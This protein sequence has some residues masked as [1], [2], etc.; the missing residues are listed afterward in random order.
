MFQSTFDSIAPLIKH[1]Y[2]KDPCDPLPSYV[3]TASIV[4]IFVSYGYLE[5][6][7]YSEVSS[8][9]GNPS[10]AEYEFR[11]FSHPSLST[12]TLPSH[13]L[14]P[15][16]HALVFLTYLECHGHQASL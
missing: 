12:I 13:A 8:Q 3:S 15:T 9:L 1:G 10:Q 14:I 16:D 4:T 2:I 7:V 6:S 5:D 11:Q